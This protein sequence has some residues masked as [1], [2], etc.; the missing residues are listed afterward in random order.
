MVLIPCLLFIGV[1]GDLMKMQV[2]FDHIKTV[3]CMLVIPL[4]LWGVKLEVN[5]AVMAETIDR[6]EQEIKK[7]EDT[8]IIVEQNR[9]TLAQL[10]ERIDAAND[11]LTDI[12]DI[13][14]DRNR[15]DRN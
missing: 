8:R 15:N 3:L 9:I 4:V 5:N 12:K 6:M 7:A 13:L 2:S 14:R 11:T 1:V 10:K